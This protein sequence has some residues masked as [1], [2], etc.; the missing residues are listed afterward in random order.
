MPF[1]VG[2][3]VEMQPS[4]PLQSAQHAQPD[5]ADLLRPRAE[6]THTFFKCILPLRSIS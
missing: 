4:V 5:M 6:V 1:L 3:V 2:R